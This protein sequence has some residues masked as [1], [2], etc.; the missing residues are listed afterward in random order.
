MIKV[1]QITSDSNIGGAGKCILT[2]LEYCNKEKFD[3]SIAMPKGSLLKPFAE[4]LGAKVYEIDCEGDKSLSVKN[5]KAYRKFLKELKPDLVHTHGNMSARIA[6][7]LEKIK[8]VFTRH[9]VFEPSPKISKGIGKIINGKVNNITADK[10]IAVAEAAKKNLTDTG[11]DESKISVILNGVKPLNER[12]TDE[13]RRELGI[14]NKKLISIIARLNEVK[15][16]KYFVDT[17]KILIEKNLPVKFLIAGTGDEAL[18][19]KKQIIEYGLEEDVIMAGFVEDV[20]EIM[21]MTD[22]QVNCSFGTEATSLSLLE[23]MSLGKP[24]VVTDFGGNTGV[25]KDGENGFV[26]PVK[27]AEKMAEKIEALVMDKALYDKISENSKK[28]FNEKFTAEKMAEEIEKIYMEVME[29]GK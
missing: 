14:E 5:I 29:N 1:V 15:G 8:T 11:V 20:T 19:I 27:N 2:Y 21:N 6:A 22:I 17:A 10:I 3:V 24:A 18:N 23:G 26:V 13:K 4:E 16:H 12:N 25:I 28:I 9:S 7:R